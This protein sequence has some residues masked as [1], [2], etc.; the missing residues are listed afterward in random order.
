MK[1]ATTSCS[2]DWQFCA[3]CAVWT[4]LPSSDSRTSLCVQLAQRRVCSRS[5]KARHP[6]TNALKSSWEECSPKS[7]L[8]TTNWSKRISINWPL[9]CWSTAATLPSA[10]SSTPSTND[11]KYIFITCRPIIYKEA[12]W[13]RFKEGE[14]K[15]QHRQAQT[16]SE[17]LFCYLRCQR[18][19][20]NCEK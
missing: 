16:R 12:V 7:P 15:D 8:F 9:C 18:I 3:V 2:K 6:R 5:T 10:P 20:F 4:L 14:G 1:V 11:H 13:K 19:R 17:Y